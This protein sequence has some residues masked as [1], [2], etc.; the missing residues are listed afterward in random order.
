MPVDPTPTEATPTYRVRGRN[1]RREEVCQRCGGVAWYVFSFREDGE[2]AKEY[3]CATC[4]NR[5]LEAAW[6]VSV[7]PS[8]PE[9][10][11][12]L[13]DANQAVVDG[14]RNRMLYYQA[15]G[16]PDE[17]QAVLQWLEAQK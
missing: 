13:V 11:D 6:L 17:A 7:R 10:A 5:W 16:R 4:H 2:T 1:Q 3:C 9:L 8:D 15:A 14:V 12:L